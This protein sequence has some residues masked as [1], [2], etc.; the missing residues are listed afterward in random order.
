MGIIAQW[1]FFGLNLYIMTC[2]VVGFY[3][4][5]ARKPH[6]LVGGDELL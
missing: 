6:P 5:S 4:D 2:Q 3:I 1:L